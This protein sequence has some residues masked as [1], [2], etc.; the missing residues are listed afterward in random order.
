MSASQ[1]KKAMAKG[2][3]DETLYTDSYARAVRKGDWKFVLE[4]G[5]RY[6]FDLSKDPAERNNLASKN[7][8]R[9]EAMDAAFLEWE[10]EVTQNVPSP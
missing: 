9:V 10:A 4:E 5:K 1:I 8:D 2:N 6:L 7:L 3:M